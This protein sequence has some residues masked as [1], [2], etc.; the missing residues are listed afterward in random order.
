M[1]PNQFI[2]SF[3]SLQKG[4]DGYC[5]LA[6][7]STKEENITNLIGFWYKI[8]KIKRQVT[9]LKVQLNSNAMQLHSETFLITGES[10]LEGMLS[11]LR[12]K[13]QDRLSLILQYPDDEQSCI[14]IEPDI[15]V[16]SV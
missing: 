4:E 10:Q 14:P 11:D 15:S 7:V 2:Q 16:N 5:R 9:V 13:A 12:L 3:E 6:S 8:V 1:T